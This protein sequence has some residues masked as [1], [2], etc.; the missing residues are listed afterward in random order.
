MG[1][2]YESLLSKDANVK[3]NFISR[4]FFAWMNGLLQ[5]GYKR[6]LTGDDLPLLSDENKAQY[7]V[8]DLYDL[9][10][11]EVTN[12]QKLGKKPQLWKAMWKLFPIQDYILILTLRLIEDAVT[13]LFPILI[14]LYLKIL[15]EKFNIDKS[16]VVYIVIG[17]GIASVIKV[18]SYHHGDYQTSVM[19]MRL[20][21]AVIGIIF[22]KV[23][24]ISMKDVYLI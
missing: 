23:I 19:G 17:I 14:W 16:Y 22:K 6:P 2:N 13:F 9:W 24:C 4:L 8:N 10:T 5:L 15:Q 21:T 7:L 18:F 12:A 1:T 11:E 3:A 20:K